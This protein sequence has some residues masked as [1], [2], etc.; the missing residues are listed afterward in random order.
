[1]WKFVCTC[2]KCRWCMMWCR[3]NWCTWC[4]L[5][6]RCSTDVG[7][8][9]DVWCDVDEIDI[10]N[11]GDAKEGCRR[12]YVDEAKHW[13]WQHFFGKKC[14]KIGN[15][16]FGTVRSQRG[17]Q[18]RPETKTYIIWSVGN[19]CLA[20][21]QL[22]TSPCYICFQPQHGSSKIFKLVMRVG[23][24]AACNWLK[25]IQKLTQKGL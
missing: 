14:K 15:Q 25:S 10:D 20:D 7:N 2:R 16:S 4:R 19:L 6:T 21:S 1:M 22:I 23:R 8:V 3:W 18:S 11:V 17:S 9:D 12:Y 24:V 13:I 5:C